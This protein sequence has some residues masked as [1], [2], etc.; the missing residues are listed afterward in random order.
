MQKMRSPLCMRLPAILF[1]VAVFYPSVFAQSNDSLENR[2]TLSDANPT[3][4]PN[5]LRATRQASEPNHAGAS[6]GRSL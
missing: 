2:L 3:A 1:L 6:A 5:S 4:V